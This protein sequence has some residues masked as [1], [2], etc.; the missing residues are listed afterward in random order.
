LAPTYFLS[1]YNDLFLHVFSEIIDKIA[2]NINSS[3]PAEEFH[4]CIFGFTGF[5]NMSISKLFSLK[6]RF[7]GYLF[8][9][10]VVK[11]GKT[12]LL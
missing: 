11:I 5:K 2:G 3:G 7:Y 4:R 1:H 12:S 6:G 9:V 8:K 10:C